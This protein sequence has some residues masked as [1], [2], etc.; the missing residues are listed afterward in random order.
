VNLVNT[1]AG[2]NGRLYWLAAIDVQNGLVTAQDT[3]GA[4]LFEDV[5][6]DGGTLLG[7]PILPGD[8][9]DAGTLY[10]CDAADLVGNANTAGLDAVVATGRERR[11]VMTIDDAFKEGDDR[12]IAI[13]LER[14]RDGV[15]QIVSDAP[16][17]EVAAPVAALARALVT[18]RTGATNEIRAKCGYPPLPQ[19]AIDAEHQQVAGLAMFYAFGER[20]GAV[21]VAIEQR[22]DALTA[23][24]DALPNVIAGLAAVKPVSTVH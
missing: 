8:R 6:V 15:K 9:I 12:L 23:R 18:W 17:A 22:L 3:N 11:A 21:F 20:L 1:G 24:L 16:A 14:L 2:G 7:A 13:M 10:L 5:T 4:L 19:A